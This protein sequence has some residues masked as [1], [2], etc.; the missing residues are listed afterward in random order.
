MQD[1]KQ[2]D[3]EEFMEDVGTALNLDTNTIQEL[4]E[5]THMLALD[6]AAPSSVLVAFSPHN[7]DIK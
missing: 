5:G 3:E 1:V 6:E 4:A 2:F 7:Q